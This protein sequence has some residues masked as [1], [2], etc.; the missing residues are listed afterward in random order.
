MDCG[1]DWGNGDWS[2]KWRIREMEAGVPNK[3]PADAG[4]RPCS[5][6]AC[7]TAPCQPWSD[8]LDNAWFSISA[9]S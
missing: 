7:S 1:R 3:P 8:T 9:L 4:E 2:R 5:L 6:Q